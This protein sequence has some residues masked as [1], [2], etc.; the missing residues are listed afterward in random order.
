MSKL[1][2]LF[3]HLTEPE[4]L[5]QYSDYLLLVVFMSSFLE[6][7]FPPIPGDTLL[8]I[9]GSITVAAHTNPLFVVIAAFTGTFCASFL[10]Y[11]L[12]LKMGK[13]LL[14]S[15]RFSW[16]MDSKTFLKIDR[17]FKRHGFLIIIASRF[18]P[19]ARSGVALAAGMVG[20]EKRRSLIALAVSILLSTLVF[21]YGGRFLGRRI[22]TIVTFW[23]NHSRRALIIALLR[24]FYF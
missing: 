21:V 24:W 1:I 5:S 14:H 8:V 3:S 12:G 15:P 19:V 11:G 10:L 13:K 6:V 16:M 20:M 4:I 7:V 23:E 17:G 22:D 9:C 18:L 2:H